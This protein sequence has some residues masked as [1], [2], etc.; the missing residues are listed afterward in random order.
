MSDHI[1]RTR[2]GASPAI[3]P[4]DDLEAERY[5]LREVLVEGSES[6]ATRREFLKVL[7]G[8]L[9]VVLITRDALAAPRIPGLAPA[10]GAALQRCEGRAELYC[11][12]R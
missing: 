5:E 6:G 11:L 2:V 8:G 1:D 10:E 7:G 12:C 3:D 9:V 4:C